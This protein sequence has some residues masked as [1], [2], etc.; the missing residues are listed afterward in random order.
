[1]AVFLGGFASPR[2]RPEHMR[3]LAARLCCACSSSPA[4]A[5]APL[6]CW[7]GVL[8]PAVAG[9]CVICRLGRSTASS[10]WSLAS[11]SLFR[12]LAARLCSACSSR[13]RPVSWR[14]LSR[15]MLLPACAGC[16]VICQH[17][18]STACSTGIPASRYGLVRPSSLSCLLLLCLSALLFASLLLP[19][20]LFAG[21]CC[22]LSFFL[23]LLRRSRV[24]CAL[25]S[26]AL[27]V[28]LFSAVAAVVS[29]L[30]FLFFSSNSFTLI[31]SSE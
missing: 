13:R 22:R 7:V 23:L 10:T 14:R 16:R 21:G 29:F 26:S 2:F 19:C 28:S 27:L 24:G 20:L 25:S 15:G 5:W 3:R 31:T 1:M 8:S 9:L 18:R 17:G 12:R 4:P 6:P 30:L 11:C